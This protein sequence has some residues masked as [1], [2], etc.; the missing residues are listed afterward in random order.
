[1]PSS[2]AMKAN[3]HEEPVDNRVRRRLRELRTE[4]GLTLQQVAERA[5][6]DIST[7]SRLEAG[8][9]RLALDHIPSLAAALG[10]STDDLLGSGPQM[11]PRVRGRVRTCDGMSMLPLSGARSPVG[12]V[13]YKI[14]VEAA[15]REPPTELPVHDGHE[16]IYVINGRMRLILGDS[17]LVINPGEAIEFST[18]IPHWF[19]AVDSPVELLAIFGPH[20]E[21]VHVH[22]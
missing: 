13:A 15:R 9:R 4:R 17:D 19:G 12:L 5:N 11:D 8:K 3:I 16:W 22:D 14:E 10:V 1:M 6:I 2:F 7:L 18:L 21:R 20:G